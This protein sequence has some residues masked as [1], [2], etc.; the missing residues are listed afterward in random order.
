[1]VNN[2]NVYTKGPDNYSTFTFWNIKLTLK[3]QDYSV[4]ENMK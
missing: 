3:E 1:M 4:H 2:V